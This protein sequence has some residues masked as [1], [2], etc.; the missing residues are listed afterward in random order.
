MR[1]LSQQRRG[2][3]R[4]RSSDGPKG[5]SGVCKMNGSSTNLFRWSTT[6]C[7]PTVKVYIVR[8]PYTSKESWGCGYREDMPLLWK[9][10][11]HCPQVSS[12]H[13][14]RQESKHAD[15]CLEKQNCSSLWEFCYNRAT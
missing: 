15:G 2:R 9:R 10:T 3:N 6:K 13:G 7:S 5:C 12:R 4:R 11:Y 14:L 1:G 8:V